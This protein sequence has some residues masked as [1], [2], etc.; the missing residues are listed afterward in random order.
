MAGLKPQ[1]GFDFNEHA[2]RTWRMNFPEAKMYTLH[3]H[4]F[5][6]MGKGNAY[7]KVD[8][9]HLSP[10]CQFFS[11]AHTVIGR[12]DDHNSASMFACGEVLKMT[13]PRIFTL[14]ETFGIMSPKF[15]PWFNAAV[16]M[17]TEL[18]YSVRWKI[19]PLQEWVSGLYNRKIDIY[20]N[21][22]RA[23]HNDVFDYL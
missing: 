16:Q 21:H 7:L 6:L 12:H 2:S 20:N 5:V 9:L 1:W 14:E 15:L 8:I 19:V 23:C 10:P 18:N 17:F 4:E 13:Q 3:S 22:C 11:P